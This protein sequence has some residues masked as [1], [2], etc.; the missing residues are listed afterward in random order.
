MPYS[1]SRLT[2][3]VVLSA[4]EEDLRQIIT[5]YLSPTMS[6]GDILGAV[7]L[8]KLKTRLEADQDVLETDN[9]LDRLLTYADFADSYEILAKHKARLPEPAARHFSIVLPRLSALTPIRNRVMHIR[10]YHYDDLAV[11][12]NTA[13][14]LV[15]DGGGVWT[16][17]SAA[18]A[19]L[20]SELGFVVG[21]EIPVYPWDT[22]T[23]SH[24]LPIPDF[25]ET[26]FVG[27]KTQVEDLVRQCLGP[28]PIIS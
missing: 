13:E 23:K 15:R 19:R 2:M 28:F 9:T 4:I 16:T 11:V 3:Y 7:L 1:V 26:G 27:R 5:L 25:D 17:L 20:K 10:P 14:E 22:L 24:N 12:T 18:M 8:G 6:T 21:L